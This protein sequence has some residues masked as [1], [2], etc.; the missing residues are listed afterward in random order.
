MKH[1]NILLLLVSF[2]IFTFSCSKDEEND[3][4][5]ADNAAFNATINGGIFTNYNATL[6][7]YSADQGIGQNNLTI[8]V[9]DANN[10]IVRLFMNET[11]GLGSGTVKQINNAD[12]NGFVTNLIFRDQE[13]QVTYSSISGSITISE[14][15][16]NPSNSEF[17]LISGSFNVI[18]STNTGTEVS[19]DGTFSNMVYLDNQ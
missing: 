13:A 19:V 8:N 2:V 17:R 7:F 4:D 6:G 18:T 12:S 11:D 9:T 14:N 1:S 5:P 15:I 16:E 10:N 3:E